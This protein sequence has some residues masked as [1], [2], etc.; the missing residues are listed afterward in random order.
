M[1]DFASTLAEAPTGLADSDRPH[2]V[3]I[4]GAG[5]S[6][7]VAA[8]VLASAG[9]EVIVLEPYERLGGNQRSR[10]IGDCT[11]DIGSFVFV[12]GSPFFRR[13]P[14]AEALCLPA[15]IRVNRITPQGRISDYPY[16]IA[17]DL[18]R[19]GPVEIVRTFLSLCYGRLA[20]SK[21]ESAA[22]FAR[23]HLGDR[24]FTQS[25]LRAYIRR[26]C[27]VSADEVEY[28][29]AQKRMAWIARTLSFSELA[30]R[31]RPRS[32]TAAA[33][34]ASLVRPREGF[35]ALFAPV[36][37]HLAERG[38]TIRLNCGIESIAPCATGFQISTSQGVVSASR[39]ISSIPLKITAQAVGIAA[40]GGVESLP[41]LT[42]YVA[43]EGDLGFEAE[44]LYN[45][46]DEGSWKRLT[47]HSRIYG[48]V[49]GRH[50]LS[51]E[52]PLAHGSREAAAEFAAFLAFMRRHG[53]MRGPAELVGH[54]VTDY[55]YPIYARGS[56]DA[57]EA[58]MDRIEA[59][60]VELLGRQGRFD[61]IP[62]ATRATQLA[63]ER[64]NRAPHAALKGSPP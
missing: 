37:A 12:A 57:S 52:A 34:P 59:T 13:F 16:S 55:A 26:L 63:V 45:F 30:A 50:Y 39:V 41:L 36:A 11:F 61:Y 2:P 28:R 33:Q 29:F 49:D 32:M 22:S 46:S 20:G 25:G 58:L 18:L 10:T 6:G 40:G 3:A 7:L 8:D 64:M 9:H 15:R 38:V 1:P 17:D 14:A 60:G 5:V 56:M 44:V 42:L 35:E 51:V 43:C 31:L 27:G 23:Y 53:L 21:P 47:A 48:Q 62:T 24:L 19:R 54:D 4:L